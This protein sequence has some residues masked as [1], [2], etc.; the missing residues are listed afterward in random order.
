MPLPEEKVLV[1]VL[2][3]GRWAQEPWLPQI[4]AVKGDRV[5]IS[6]AIAY[7]LQKKGKCRIVPN[8]T[9]NE[10]TDDKGV[11]DEGVDDEPKE[12]K[13]KP[14]KQVKRKSEN[15]PSKRDKERAEG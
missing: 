13:K 3:D 9:G 5:S 15:N 14:P 12:S 1:E 2:K 4:V 7:V 11:D 6:I 8:A 10:V